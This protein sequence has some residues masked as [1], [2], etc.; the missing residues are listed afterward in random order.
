MISQS[1]EKVTFSVEGQGGEESVFRRV[2]FIYFSLLYF[3]LNPG[4][5]NTFMTSLIA[6]CL[7]SLT[8]H[9][10]DALPTSLAGEEEPIR[11][12]FTITISLLS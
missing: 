10:K 3:V 5:F 8:G 9:H 1:A 4:D 7:L 12:K 6:Q 2:F 11:Q